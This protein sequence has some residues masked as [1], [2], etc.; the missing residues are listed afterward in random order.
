MSTQRP[1]IQGYLDPQLYDLFL[2]WKKQRGVPKESEALNQILKE[3][4][5]VQ[6]SND[7]IPNPQNFI[8][9]EKIEKM[10]E[11]ECSSRMQEIKEHIASKL[12]TL[13][14]LDS[15]IDGYV[16]E[17]MVQQSE[18]W[19]NQLGEKF[20]SRIY[21]LERRL[22][23][24]RDKYKEEDDRLTAVEDSLEALLEFSP[25]DSLDSTRSPKPT[26]RHE[27]LSPSPEAI[28]T[29][30]IEALEGSKVQ[31]NE[32]R[33]EIPSELN[34]SQLARRLNISKSV[35]SR[36]KTKPDFKEWSKSKDPEGTTWSYDA[37]RQIFGGI[38]L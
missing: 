28:S 10:I 32:T 11:E 31:K 35:V 34:L 27:N 18:E 26:A 6:N 3:Y 33:G 4:F 24:L 9:T 22:D 29:R 19:M 23:A 7:S 5:G 8:L 16:Q 15:K 17:R 37:E 13:T 1:R 38:A 36:R 30:V 20:H 12:P 14:E 25:G 21:A 2:G